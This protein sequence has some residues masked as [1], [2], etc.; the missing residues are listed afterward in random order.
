MKRE[1]IEKLE[2]TMMNMLDNI[3]MSDSNTEE[4]LE[5]IKQLTTLLKTYNE[6]LSKNVELEQKQDEIKFKHKEKPPPSLWLPISPHCAWCI[7]CFASV[8]PPLL[9]EI[10]AQ[11]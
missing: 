10:A 3:E 9:V 4:G 6:I 7:L 2:N 5:E 11:P 8:K 1:L